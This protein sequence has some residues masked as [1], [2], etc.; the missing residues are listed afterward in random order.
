MIASG[1]PTHELD[2]EIPE[3]VL[4]AD[5]VAAPPEAVVPGEGLM[6]PSY[7]AVTIGVVAAMTMF[8]FEGIGVASAMPVVARSL[9]GLDV[10][11]WVFNG[12][13]VAS[14]VAMVL[15]GEWCDRAGPRPPLTLGISLFA[16]G[17]AIAGAAWSMPVLVAARAV[18]GFGMGLAIVAVYVVI[19]RAY[20]ESLRPKTFA[21]LS[22]AWVVPAIVG[23]LIAGFLT[24]HVSWRA[25]FWCVVPFVIPPLLLLVPRTRG[26]GGTLEE[27]AERRGRVRLA[28][29]AAAGLALVQEAGTRLG[30]IGAVLLVVGLAVLLPMLR[31]LLPAGA[32]RFARGLPTVVVMRGVLAGA[33]FAG[34]AFVP[35]ALQTVRGASTAQAGVAL[36]V[37]AIG[38]AAGSQVQGR[39]YARLPQGRLVE[40]GA[41]FVAFCLSWAVLSLVPSLSFWVI[42]PG[43]M[44][45]AM[46]MGMSFGS[47]G[48]LVLE[49]SPPEDQGA[50]VASLQVCDSV[51]SVLLVGLAG[52]IY[53]TALAAGAVTSS[54]FITIWLVMAALALAGAVLARRIRV[55]PSS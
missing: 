20:P 55:K 15:A 6:G 33:F 14:L 12:Y 30:R 32:L 40:I 16:L 46:G 54:T 34:E 39:L 50:N 17:A 5:A 8:A 21:V 27:G 13:I 37:G 26:F 42:I 53:G 29:V 3:Q 52:A 45:G 10:Y 31:L 2:V 35:L 9:E 36:T 4:A 7:R 11:A 48:S 18:Q 22:A 24:D 1:S 38:W 49:L 51:G 25:V 43:W 19:G 23:P 41:L 28:V 47:I 44:V